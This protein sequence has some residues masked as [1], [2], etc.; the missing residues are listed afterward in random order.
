MKRTLLIGFILIISGW[1]FAQDNEIEP[2]GYNIFYHDNGEISSEG[3]MRNGEPDGYWKTYYESGIIKSEGNRLN[4]QLDS[5]WSFYN[6]EGELILQI[7]YKED[8]KNGL[9]RIIREKEIVEENFVNDVKQG[10]TKYYFTDGKLKKTVPFVD[11]LE[12]GMALEYNEEGMIINLIEYKK[13]FIVNRDKINRKDKNGLKQ[14]KW[15]YFYDDGIVRQEG[16]YRND[17][18]NGYFKEYDKD[19]NLVIVSKYIDDILQ[20]DVAELVELEVRTDYYPNGTIKTIASYKDS[21][22]EGVRR[23]YDENGR[24]KMAYI[25]SKGDIIGQGILNEDGEKEGD[26]KEYFKDGNLKA[27]GRY[28]DGK[29]V[30][31]WKFYHENGNLEQSGKYNEHGELDGTWRWYYLSGELLRED[32]YMNDLADGHLIEYSEDGKVITEGD[33]I[34]GYEDGYWIYESPF[35]KEEGNWRDGMRNGKWKSYW[36]DGQLSFS[37]DFIDDNPNGR[38]TWYWDNGQIKDE[39]R[40]IM[41]RKDGDWIKYNYDGTVFIVISFKNGIEKKYDGI[42]IKPEMEEE[43]FDE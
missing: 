6:E 16:N 7:T 12:N 2:N 1:L 32:N 19:G 41:G 34:E 39:G 30:G 4:F 13:G 10:I 11:G 29:R 38:H 35:H 22:P 15:I 5:I 31:Q 20:E 23:E 25:F 36:D 17:M 18:K 27:E 42:R 33:Y 3:M 28:K 24:I 40:Y 8:K 37:G 21:I 26:W 14:G 9:R 43:D